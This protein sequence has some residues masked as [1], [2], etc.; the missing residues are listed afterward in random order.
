MNCD[1]KF[2]HQLVLFNDKIKMHS[3]RKYGPNSINNTHQVDGKDEYI[4]GSVT[5]DELKSAIKQTNEIFKKQNIIV[6]F[7]DRVIQLFWYNEFQ[8]LMSDGVQDQKS[9]DH[10]KFMKQVD[11]IPEY[12]YSRY[13]F[14]DPVQKAQY[15]EVAPKSNQSQ[16][17]LKSNLSKTQKYFY[18]EDIAKIIYPHNKI[19]IEKKE[20]KITSRRKKSENR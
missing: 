1:L 11:I 13:K 5:R 12:K 2:D 15:L 6:E 8:V 9:D 18:N 16:N 20:E 17:M 14:K 19:K 4:W 3:I 10:I 7:P